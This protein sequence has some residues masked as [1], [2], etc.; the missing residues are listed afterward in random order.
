[1][2]GDAIYMVVT[3]ATGRAGRAPE[4]AFDSPGRRVVRKVANRAHVNS[5]RSNMVGDAIYMV[6]T[7]ATGRTNRAPSGAFD[8]PGRRV[9]R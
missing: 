5:T 6:V 7:A 9:V 4:G 2:F 3:A 1:M 8:S